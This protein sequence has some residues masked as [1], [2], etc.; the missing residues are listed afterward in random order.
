[1]LHQVT[2][3]GESDCETIADAALAQPMNAL[4]SLAFSVIGIGMIVWA[5]SVRGIERE[6]RI[7]FGS[8]LF[9]TGIGSYLFHGPQP[10]ASQFLHD[11]TFLAALLLIV[12]AHLAAGLSWSRQTLWGVLSAAILVVSCTLLAYPHAT[13]AFMVAGVAGIVLSHIALRRVGRASRRLLLSAMLA[14][15]LAVT[16][17]VL[18]RAGG[19]ICDP[20]STFQGH[21]MWHILS[22]IGIATYF[23][24]TSPPRVTS[25]G[26]AL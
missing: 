18:G 9:L 19:P 10:S 6:L 23:A 11:I 5:Q 7:M 22:A 13:N 12:V 3:L 8:I 20:D 17:F 21:A 15:A 4:S 2:A 14:L 16:F 24:A 25:L 26:S 1:M